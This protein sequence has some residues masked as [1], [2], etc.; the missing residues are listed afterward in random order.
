MRQA[1]ICISGEAPSRQIA[2]P[3]MRQERVVICANGGLMTAQRLGLTP[4]VIIGDL[5]SIDALNVDRARTR[6]IAHSRD[7]DATDTQLAVAHS[8]SIHCS[9]RL[10]VGG[11][12][13]RLDHLA[14]LLWNFETPEYAV[15]R[16]I[17]DHV[18]VDHLAPGAHNFAVTRNDILSILPCGEG[19]WTA[20][21]RGLRWPL[22]NTAWSRADYGIC[23]E[24]VADTITLTIT[25]GRLLLMR[26]HRQPSDAVSAR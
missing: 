15:N 26:F 13:G 9:E 12:G 22:D 1:V 2:L 4:Q 14:A 18:I 10:L 3:F 7:K 16:W 11:G 21:S 17:T 8:R 5:D 19:P 25:A 23:N 6:I 20:K 24:A